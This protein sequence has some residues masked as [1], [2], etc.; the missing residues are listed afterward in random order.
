MTTHYWTWLLR[1]EGP[2]GLILLAFIGL[3]CGAFWWY[4][5][6]VDHTGYVPTTARLISVESSISRRA[7]SRVILTAQ[8]TDGLF[9]TK[10]IA[11]DE[12]KTCKVGDDVKAERKNLRVSLLDD[13]CR[14]P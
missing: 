2:A 5:Q 11:P 12:A 8:T 9:V 1:R 13:P 14:H 7:P 4:A 3:I 6:P 10:A